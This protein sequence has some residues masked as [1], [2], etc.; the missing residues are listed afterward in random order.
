MFSETA[1]W[2]LISVVALASTCQA[3]TG[4]GKCPD[5]PVKSNLNVK[6]VSEDA[7]V[8][9]TNLHCDLLCVLKRIM[10]QYSS[11]SKTDR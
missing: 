6:N 7:T 3:V 5:P 2:S 9:A 8:Y 1:I 4:G 11:Y 10:S